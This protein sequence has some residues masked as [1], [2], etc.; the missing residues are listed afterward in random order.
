M[1]NVL[2]KNSEEELTEFD[3]DHGKLGAFLIYL[4]VFSIF[5]LLMLILF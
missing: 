5:L 1:E 2:D 4:A 3:S